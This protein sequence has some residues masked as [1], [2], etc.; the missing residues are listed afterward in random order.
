MKLLAILLFGAA[1][2]ASAALAAA[3]TPPAP[4]PGPRG[5]G[6][7]GLPPQLAA[8]LGLTDDQK[9]T[10]ESMHKEQIESTRPLFEKERTLEREMETLL[11]SGKADPATVGKN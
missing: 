10:L 11:D 5:I 7:P 3:P 8:V 4:P 1:I 2:A 6:G 9:A